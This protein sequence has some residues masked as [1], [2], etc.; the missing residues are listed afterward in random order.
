MRGRSRHSGC[1]GAGPRRG[2]P[3][4]LDS[5]VRRG[6]R[7]GSSTPQREGRLCV[8]L[9]LPVTCGPWRRTERTLSAGQRPRI[10]AGAW[11]GPGRL[12]MCRAERKCALACTPPGRLHPPVP[13]QQ[14]GARNESC[15]ARAW[16]AAV[17][18]I[19]HRLAPM[20]T[21]LGAAESGFNG[22]TLGCMPAGSWMHQYHITTLQKGLSSCHHRH[23]QLW[24]PT[25]ATRRQLRGA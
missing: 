3:Q 23:C 18:H 4:L 1:S 9:R 5:A 15:N 21:C 17:H 22:I 11:A 10:F 16:Q 8:C 13:C 6:V 14:S 19:G 24:A 7:T 20:F 25:S 2:V 12:L